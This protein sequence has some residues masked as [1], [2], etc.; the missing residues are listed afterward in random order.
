MPARSSTF[1]SFVIAF[2]ILSF[3]VLTPD[4]Y[5]GSSLLTHIGSLNTTSEYGHWWYTGANPTLL[6][7]TTAS[8]SVT[9]T[10]DSVSQTVTADEQGNW[11]HPTSISS[12]DH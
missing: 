4:V 1:F 5:A 12:G 2:L 10:I 11:S 8:G 6:G 7:Q 3:I 9:V